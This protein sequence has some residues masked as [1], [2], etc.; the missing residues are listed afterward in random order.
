VNTGINI[1]GPQ[2][3]SIYSGPPPPPISRASTGA[4]SNVAEP[5]DLS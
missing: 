5:M 3:Q 4:G 1:P 2:M